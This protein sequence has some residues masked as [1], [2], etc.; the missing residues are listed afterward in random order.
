MVY[1]DPAVRRA[2]L[3]ALVIGLVA[4]GSALGFSKQ[5]VTLT[6]SDGVTLGTTLY[7]PDGPAPASGHPTILMLHG[8]NGRRQDLHP[9]AESVFVSRGYAVMTFDA[10]GHGESGGQITVAGP[11]EMQDLTTIFRWLIDRPDIGRIG[12]WGIS[13]GGGQILRAACEGLSF[14]ALVPLETW[15]NLHE[16]LIPQDLAKSGVIAGFVTGMRPDAVSP[17]VQM[18]REDAFAGRN[19]AGIRAF[20]E[21]RS[22]RQSLQL[23]LRAPTYFF[24]GRRDFVFDISQAV[25]GF[26]RV[27]PAKRLYIGAFGHSPSRFPGPDAAIVFAE[28]AAWF[29]RWLKGIPNG[30]DKGPRVKLAPDPFR[31]RVVSFPSLPPTRTIT[32]PLAGTRTIA[33]TGRVVRTAGRTSGLLET[34]G[35]SVVNV[36]ATSLGGWS[37]LVATLTATTPKGQEIVVS[38]GGTRTQP[39]RRA[40][41]IKLLSQ[42]TLIPARSRLRLVL[43]GD[44]SKQAAGNLLY[45]DLPMTRGAR[46][47]VGAADL[48]LRVLR[49]PV[50]R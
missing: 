41:A 6:M 32:F 27:R 44:T 5:D 28:S 10:R 35:T 25:A 38:A 4:P 31:G 8:L 11:R 9:I 23:D 15:T 29:D 50:S 20:S 22:T 42:A 12:G 36:R 30:I 21:V 45:L 24:Q 34:F 1:P 48:R 18:L 26:Q 7:L 19:L 40:Y 49:K 3:L 37:R 46:V 16:A 17:I 13:Y 43:A 33:T 14:S 47:T 39:G 2:L